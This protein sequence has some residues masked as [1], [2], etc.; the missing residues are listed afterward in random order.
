MKTCIGLQSNKCSVKSTPTSL[1]HA[2]VEVGVGGGEALEVPVN[3]PVRANLVGLVGLTLG[4]GPPH[5]QRGTSRSCNPLL[6]KRP[7]L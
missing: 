7:A 3:S 2:K 5:C 6:L 4:R 1:W